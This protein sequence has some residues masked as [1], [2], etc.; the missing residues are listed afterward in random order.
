MPPLRYPKGATL[1]I[2]K[3]LRLQPQV[4]SIQENVNELPYYTSV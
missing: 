1:A 3:L 2:E 4:A